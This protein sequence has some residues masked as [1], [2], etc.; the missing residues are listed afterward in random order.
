MKWKKLLSFAIVTVLVFSVLVAFV[1][2]TRADEEGTPIDE[3][4][5]QV[6]FEMSDGAAAAAEGDV[7]LFMHSVDGPVYQGLPGDF[8]AALDTW[9]VFGTY[10]SY[11]I[12]P[13]HEGSGTPEAL[14]AETEEW[15]EDP[16]DFRYLANNVD[17]DWTVNPFA[18]N[19]IR[20]AF[21]YL[22]REEMVED[23]LEGFGLPRYGAMAA[24]IPMWEEVFEEPIREGYDM[25]PEG[26]WARVE[27]MVEEAMN[28]IAE[29]YRSAN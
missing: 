2:P 13:A 12:N 23:L 20:F 28:E 3:I 24:N 14:E 5:F 27:W 22:N 6:T 4:N 26:D 9:D 15:I 18:H 16:A 17:G 10:N 19:D 7:H 25:S 8:L 21:Q 29:R 1:S 11:L